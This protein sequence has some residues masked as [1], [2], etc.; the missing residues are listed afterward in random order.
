[1]SMIARASSRFPLILAFTC[2]V[3][4]GMM[5]GLL[6]VAWPS[7]RATFG[8]ALDTLAV[9]LAA[10]TIGIVTGSFL[11]A[12]IMAR[13]GVGWALMLANL[14]GMVAAIGYALAPAWWVMVVSGIGWGLAQGTIN[15]SLNIYVSATRSVAP[16]AATQLVG[17]CAFGYAGSVAGV[18]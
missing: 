5:G 2:Y 17:A 14:I 15:A 7:V 6:S 3:A 12:Q 9:L 4:L 8:L 11:S 18:A 16:I 13:I 10:S 1:M